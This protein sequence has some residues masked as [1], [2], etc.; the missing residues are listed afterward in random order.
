MGHHDATA[1]Q[2][3]DASALLADLRRILPPAALH[4]LADD[5]GVKS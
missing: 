1:G 3:F 2:D 4:R 5:K